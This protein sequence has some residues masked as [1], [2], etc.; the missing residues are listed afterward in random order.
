MLIY[1]SINFLHNVY[2]LETCCGTAGQKGM[3]QMLVAQTGTSGLKMRGQDVGWLTIRFII[4]GWTAA[5]QGQHFNRECLSPSRALSDRD[6]P[7]LGVSD[8]VSVSPMNL[9]GSQL[10]CLRY[11]RSI[12]WST[13]SICGCCCRRSFNAGAYRG[14]SPRARWR[15]KGP[16]G[17]SK[18]IIHRKKK[19]N[20]A[21][22]LCGFLLA[23]TQIR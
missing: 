18:K 3:L 4:F 13:S 15:E 8:D 14:S 21:S 5:M 1:K 6:T 2:T 22:T 12:S 16:W 11:R 17:L 23:E 7:L 9:C 10:V 20:H 19:K